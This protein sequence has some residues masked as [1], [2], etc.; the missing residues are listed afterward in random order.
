MRKL[1]TAEAWIEDSADMIDLCAPDS[2]LAAGAEG[3]VAGGA[4]ELDYRRSASLSV[5]G[6][7]SE[8]MRSIIAQLALGLPRSRS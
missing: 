3:V 5:Y 8:I 2:I 7:S 4:V 6:G 1:F